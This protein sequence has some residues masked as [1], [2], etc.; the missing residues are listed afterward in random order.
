MNTAGK[1]LSPFWAPIA[2]LFSAES[3]RSIADQWR[4]AAALYALGV[5]SISWLALSPLIHQ[6]A[7]N[8]IGEITDAILAK[9]PSL[10]L[11]GG[12]LTCDVEMPVEI[13]DPR[14]GRV[15]AVVDTNI[16]GVEPAFEPSDFPF[17]LVTG[18]RLLYARDKSETRIIKFAS[19]PD[20]TLNGEGLRKYEKMARQLFLPLTLLLMIPSFFVFYLVKTLLWVILAVAVSSLGSREWSFLPL[21]RI[22]IVAGTP[23][24]IV[25]TISNLSPIFFWSVPFSMGLTFAYTIF[26]T[27]SLP[28][29]K[30]TPAQSDQNSLN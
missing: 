7:G 22:C 4:G 16:V 14:S 25:A 18:D 20:F 8:Q 6:S 9:I 23:S 26:G 11:K 1:K 10:S 21:Y 5:T 13:A 12:V 28:R 2:C 27:L 17:A 30:T 15:F 3:Y 29:L 19:V 24:L